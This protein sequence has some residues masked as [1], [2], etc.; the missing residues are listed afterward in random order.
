MY[1][2]FLTVHTAYSII[3]SVYLASIT[4]QSFYEEPFLAAFSLFM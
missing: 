4:Q 3:L 2:L 1:T